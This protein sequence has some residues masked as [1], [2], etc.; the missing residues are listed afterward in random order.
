MKRCKNCGATIHEGDTF[1]RTC[2]TPIEEM[3]FTNDKDNVATNDFMSPSLPSTTQPTKIVYKKEGQ[4]FTE[5]VKDKMGIPDS[6]PK[7]NKQYVERDGNDRAKAT[8]FNFFTASTYKIN[9]SNNSFCASSLV[10][11]AEYCS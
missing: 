10:I 4:S 7:D 9:A 8:L 2:A 1:C 3:N 11:F 5:M 6:T